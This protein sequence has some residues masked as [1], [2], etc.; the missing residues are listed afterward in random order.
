M[1]TFLAKHRRAL[2]VTTGVLV[3]AAAFSAYTLLSPLSSSGDVQRI[4]VDADDTA[5]SVRAKVLAHASWHGAIGLRLAT[6]FLSG[7]DSVHPGSY[8]I[9]S[10][11]S[12]VAVVRRLRAGRQ[13]PV[14]LT[15]PSVWTMNDLAGRL[16]RVMFADSATWA[17]H[18]ADSIWC[19]GFGCTPQTLPA[20]YLTNTYEVYWTDGPDELT[21]RMQ[22]ESQ[23]YWTEERTALARQQ[24]LTP[25]E[26]V[27]L[28]SI[29]DRETAAES[30]KA[31]VAG[32]YL[33]RLRKGMKLQADPTVKFALQQ[34]GL[35]RLLH[36]HLTT[37]SPYNT[38]V[39][40]G[41]P[42]GPIALPSRSSIEAVLHPVNHDYLYM[43]ANEDFSGTHRFA[44]TYEEHLQNAA[45]YARALDARQIR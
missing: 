44:R 5:D 38:Y 4:Y 40:E 7:G 21:R 3:A 32:M 30:E 42:P 28:A 18:F 29:V 34:F 26:A 23:T 25:T 17:V 35:R 41:L 9:G 16:S 11:Q 33:A 45:R 6:T 39:N 15:I 14:R 8:D 31:M 13:T 12:A 2:L 24:G 10:R 43:C 36:G 1:R 20:L 22:R 37:P 27:V 19:A